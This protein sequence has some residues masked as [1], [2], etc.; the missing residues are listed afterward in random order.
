MFFD[1]AQKRKFV[2]SVS[3]LRH[4]FLNFIH[5]SLKLACLFLVFDFFFLCCLSV[6]FCFR[7]IECFQLHWLGV[8]KPFFMFIFHFFSVLT[9]LLFRHKPSFYGQ[10]YGCRANNETRCSE[11][12]NP[13]IQHKLST[14]HR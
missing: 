6:L 3:V 4:F 7:S 9:S 5:L 10:L 11:T 13:N 12:H 2:L 1:F 8:N 14:A